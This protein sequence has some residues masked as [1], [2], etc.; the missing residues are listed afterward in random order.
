M[1]ET[2]ASCV[3]VPAGPW[4]SPGPEACPAAAGQLHPP[5]T[6]HVAFRGTGPRG[7]LLPP[8]PPPPAGT[9]PVSGRQERVCR[10]RG[11]GLLEG[12]EG[13]RASQRS[14]GGWG[15]PGRLPGGV[16]QGHGNAHGPASRPRGLPQTR[17]PLRLGAH[18]VCGGHIAE[19]SGSSVALT[20]V[21]G[22]AGEGVRTQERRLTPSPVCVPDSGPQLV[23]RA[24]IS[25]FRPHPLVEQLRALMARGSGQW[26]K[27]KGS[28]PP[29]S[30]APR[31]GLRSLSP[32]LLRP[33]GGQGGRRLMRKGSDLLSRARD[34]PQGPAPCACSSQG[35]SVGP[36]SCSRGCRGP[37]TPP[38]L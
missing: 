37:H 9:W 26:L 1:A 29:Q 34:S 7:H 5:S 8:P 27:P 15:G 10:A 36:S 28:G 24:R 4:W 16:S 20:G 31:Q 33:R 22:T 11:P 13:R 18:R 30:P 23:R 3:R 32:R 14:P 25:C 2:D 12:P 21:A 38:H 19:G 17:A 6:L 35:S